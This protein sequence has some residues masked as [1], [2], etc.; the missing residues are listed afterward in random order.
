MPDRKKKRLSRVEIVLADDKPRTL[1]YTL[2]EICEIN[3]LH[4]SGTLADPR[5]FARVVQLGL[6]HESPDLTVEEVARLI[7]APNLDY[8]RDCVNEASFAG[9][10]PAAAPPAA[11]GNG[12][13]LETGNDSAPGRASTADSTNALSGNLRP[14]S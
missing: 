14:V 13:V 1:L 11:L 10:A 12:R 7:D 4:S 9:E 5:N 2:N 8:Y 3:E 6:R